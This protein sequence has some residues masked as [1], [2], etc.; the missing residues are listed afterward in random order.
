MRV[1]MRN[2]ELGSMDEIRLGQNNVL[3]SAS[4]EVIGAN[5]EMYRCHGKSYDQMW[6]SSFGPSLDATLQSDL[7]RIAGNYS[8]SPEGLRCLD[9]GA[10]TGAVTLSMLARGWSVTAIDVSPDM[11][12]LLKNKIAAR[13]L[14]G[15]TLINEPAERFL[16]SEGPTYHL[17]AFNSVLHHI[18]KYRAVVSLAA[19]HLVPG[20]FLYTNVDRVMPSIPAVAEFLDSLDT[21]LAKLSYE[22]SDLIPGTIR[23]VRKF[24][25]RTDPTYR[26]KI[27]SVGDLAE[28]HAR[29]GVDDIDLVRLLK[30][31]GLGIVEHSRYPLARTGVGKHLN[32]LLKFREE[33]K[34]VAQKK[35]ATG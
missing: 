16:A 19:D 10:G 28:F 18:Y 31:K 13:K 4:S 30:Q 25:G 35:G 29:S 12:E 22:R 24:F 27:A 1:Q 11:L 33:F 15:A 3:E 20:G 14:N 17:I 34:I 7:D 2:S 9:C 6:G 5:V 26:R 21:I 8:G 23:R 32:G